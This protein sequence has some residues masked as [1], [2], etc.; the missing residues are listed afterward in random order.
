MTELH[1]DRR[2]IAATDYELKVVEQATDR[3]LR[4][5]SAVTLVPFLPTEGPILV[6]LQLDAADPSRNEQ[7]KQAINFDAQ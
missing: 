2:F 7:I 6:V 1:G 5:I 3:R 4:L